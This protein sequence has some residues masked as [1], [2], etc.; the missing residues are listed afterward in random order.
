[1]QLGTTSTVVVLLTVRRG[2]LQTG[3]GVACH[4]AVDE[5]KAST[6]PP[7]SLSRLSHW[8]SR[9]SVAVQVR[10]GDRPL[11]PPHPSARVTGGGHIPVV[12]Q[13]SQ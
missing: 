1:M 8:S 4:A 2:M 7:A 3:A 11:L 9:H 13:A 5:H 12:Q 10:C 6:Q